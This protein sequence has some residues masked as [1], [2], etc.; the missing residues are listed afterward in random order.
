MLTHTRGQT[1]VVVIAHHP[2]SG[3]MFWPNGIHPT[4]HRIFHITR[5]GVAIQIHQIEV[6]RDLG[7][8][9][10]AV[11]DVIT[12]NFNRGISLSNQDAVEE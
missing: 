12:Q 3:L 10:A 2:V 6:H 11:V 4:P 8:H 7:A 9:M 1:I 5:R